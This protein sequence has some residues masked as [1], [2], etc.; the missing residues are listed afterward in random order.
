[1]ASPNDRDHQET[2]PPALTAHDLD[3]GEVPD[4]EAATK[5]GSSM[6][7]SFAA[8]GTIQLIQAVIGVL[9]ARILG[10]EDR[11]EL[12][13]VILW[14]TLLTTIGSFGL[15][16]S[17]TYFAARSKDTATLVGTTLGLVAADAVL[18]I[19][20]GLA[21]VP[22]VL[23]GHESDVV[24][25]TQL[26]L[27]AFVPLNLLVITMNS[28]L[29]GLHRF[30]WFQSIRVLMIVVTLA[31][32]GAFALVDELTI[33]N[34]AI[35]YVA[36]FAV[37]AILATGV[38]L[39][40]TGLRLGFERAMARQLLGF[41]FKAQFSTSLWSLNERADQLVISAFLS[42]T[43]LGL[44]VVAVT[45]TSLTTLV[46]FSFALVA[47]PLIARLDSEEEKRRVARLVVSSTLAAGVLVSVPIFVAE[48]WLIDL[49]FG[50][51]FA[52]AADVG[53]V[54]LVGGVVFALSR[55]LESVLQALGR[56]LD[57]SVG[58][59][60]ALIMTAA[61]LA[62]LLPLMGIMGAGI[63]SVLAYSVGATY[64]LFRVRKVL[65]LSIR[66]MLIPPRD[67]YGRLRSLGGSFRTAGR[68]R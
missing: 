16:Q 7:G 36:G 2:A 60:L 66:K 6:A 38:V 20:I 67:L 55:V 52:E 4:A 8:T 63:T 28:I 68:G 27:V 29:N 53:R 62:A 44:Y 11:G 13:A 15:A 18:L 3:T 9:L 32:L 26:F 34:A 48:P 22:L 23:S 42:A 24:H 31:T 58:E 39:R 12:A 46:G 43:S 5:V 59:G 41:G 40:T 14:P 33:R 35:G 19:G 37:T 45:L 51:E 47:L 61:G 65:G 57:S 56:P 21:I 30:A 1:M 49:L 50:S 25:T 54:L 64:L 17:V 10:P